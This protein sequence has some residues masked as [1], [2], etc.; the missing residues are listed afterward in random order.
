M[1]MWHFVLYSA[2]AMLAL[3]SFIQLVTN[4][5]NEFEHDAVRN[6]LTR[7][8]EEMKADSKRD[9]SARPAKEP[10]VKPEKQP[11]GV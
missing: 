10:D 3:R 7:M 1:S 4:Y 6:Q 8:A 9:P 5:R 2:A 11:A